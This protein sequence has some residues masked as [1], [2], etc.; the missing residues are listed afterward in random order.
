MISG[1]RIVEWLFIPLETCVSSSS[2]DVS[3]Y[4]EGKETM[5]PSCSRQYVKEDTANKLQ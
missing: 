3:R 5:S 4:V 1:E 2:F